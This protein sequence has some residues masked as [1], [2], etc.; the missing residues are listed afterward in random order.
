MITEDQLKMRIN[1]QNGSDRKTPRPLTV[2]VIL[3]AV[4]G[5]LAYSLFNHLKQVSAPE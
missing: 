5:L 1:D 3:L 4:L 2:A